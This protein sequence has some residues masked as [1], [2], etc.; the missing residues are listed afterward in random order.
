MISK[1]CSNNCLWVINI[2][3]LRRLR[4]FDHCSPL[5]KGW[6]WCKAFDIL[7]HHQVCNIY[8]FSDK[9]TMVWTWCIPM[10]WWT[11]IRTWTGYPEDVKEWWK[12]NLCCSGSLHASDKCFV[13]CL[14]SSD[15]L[16]WNGLQALCYLCSPVRFN[17]Y[18]IIM[19]PLCLYT[20]WYIFSWQL[21]SRTPC[22]RR[23]GLHG[24]YVWMS[25]HGSHA[26]VVQDISNA[27][28][29]V[30]RVHKFSWSETHGCAW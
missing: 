4:L 5:L 29:L 21:A 11:E 8:V 26:H 20:T 17:Q 9:K 3:R 14:V 27:V 2:L 16:S 25:Y 24:C 7:S 19:R 18:W 12:T 6:L 13:A 28:A 15:I 10:L 22:V 23:A 1:C 30:L